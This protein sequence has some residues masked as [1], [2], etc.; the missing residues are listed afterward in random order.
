M[1]LSVLLYRGQGE[2]LTID[3]RELHLQLYGLLLDAPLQPLA[4][5]ED[6]PLPDDS[7]G[8]PCALSL[9]DMQ[10]WTWVDLVCTVPAKCVT[11]IK[12]ALPALQDL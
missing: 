5:A 10:A 7:D 1:W 6:D 9:L 4:A 12:C 2:A 3:R 8:A 11:C